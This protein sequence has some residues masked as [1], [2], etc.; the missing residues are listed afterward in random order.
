M[1]NSNKMPS[2]TTKRQMVGLLMKLFQ[3]NPQE[4]YSLSEIVKILKLK[5]HPSKLLCTDILDDL[6]A[7]DFI[8]ITREHTYRL[9]TRNQVMEGVFQR[10]R[11]GRNSFLPD[12]EDKGILV[13]ERNSHHALNGDRVK[14]TLLARRRNHTRE[15]E[16]IE[17]VKRAHDNIL[18]TL[19]VEKSYAFLLTHDRT[20]AADIFIPKSSLK[21]GKTGE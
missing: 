11:N 13:M 18:G 20:L 15:A 12:G 9:T 14:A 19:K 2:R 6:I 7:D 5:T 21:H 16:V 8:S 10:K 4:E 1:G 3:S 17:V